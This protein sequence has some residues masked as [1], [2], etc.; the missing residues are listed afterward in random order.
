MFLLGI[1]VSDL[2]CFVCNSLAF[3]FLDYLQPLSFFARNL[4]KLLLRLSLIKTNNSVY[5]LTYL[6]ARKLNMLWYA[7][8]EQIAGICH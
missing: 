1:E 2:F 6:G 3:A 5:L 4:D 8:R 7:A